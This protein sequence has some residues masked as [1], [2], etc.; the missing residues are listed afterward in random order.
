[1]QRGFLR[2]AQRASGCPGSA[3]KVCVVQCHFSSLANSKYPG[4][5][6]ALHLSPTP[7]KLRDFLTQACPLGVQYI[8]LVP[9]PSLNWTHIHVWNLWLPY[10]R[11]SILVS[12]KIS[13]FHLFFQRAACFH[14]KPS[15]SSIERIS[16]QAVPLHAAHIL[17]LSFSCLGYCFF[18]RLKSPSCS[19]NGNQLL[20]LTLFF[21]PWT[22]LVFLYLFWSG[23]PELQLVLK[24][25]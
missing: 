11:C 19:I 2:L 24:M 20:M 13:S 25:Q 15:I 9:F 23:G 1:M 5:A 18:F 6:P 21:L 8:S 3:Q 16:G 4:D 14:P 17:A 22:Y 7:W 12:W 10:C